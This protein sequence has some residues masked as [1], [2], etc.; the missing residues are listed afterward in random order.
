MV[1][2]EHMGNSLDGMFFQTPVF[3]FETSL[4]AKQGCEMKGIRPKFGL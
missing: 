1:C 2:M 4:I 3:V